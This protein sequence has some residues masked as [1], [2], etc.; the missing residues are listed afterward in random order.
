MPKGAITNI[1]KSDSIFV[2]TF[3]HHH[4]LPEITF[5]G[6]CLIQNNICIPE[7]LVNLH[8]SYTL[9]PWLGNLNTDFTL[10]SCLFGSVKLTKNADRDKYKYSDY[11]T[12]FD[13]PSAFSFT[14]GFMG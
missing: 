7:K 8:I 13:S 3:V 1:T 5:N 10:N 9:T 11:I 6:H 4:L 2:P 14:D 12:G